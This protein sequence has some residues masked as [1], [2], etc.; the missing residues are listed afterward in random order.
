MAEDTKPDTPTAKPEAKAAK[1]KKAKPP[2]LE[3]KPF[4]E[5]IEQHFTP[6]LQQAFTD[7]G[8]EDMEL[9]FT[10]QEIPIAGVKSD[11]EFWQ[12]IGNWQNGKRQFNLYFLEDNIS[13]KKAFS[14]ATNG[15][16]PSTIESFMI[17]ERKVTLDLLV[18]YTLQRLNGQK[19]LTGN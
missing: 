7:E 15:K 5:F 11:T 3:D 9:N 2:K 19:W 4:E 6:T 8:I 16:Q 18:L 17:D 1:P 13:G 12:I 14:Y 10:K